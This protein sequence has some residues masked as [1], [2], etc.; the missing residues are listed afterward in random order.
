MAE[1]TSVIE[2]PAPAVPVMDEDDFIAMQMAMDS[3]EGDAPVVPEETGAKEKPAAPAKKK[4]EEKAPTVEP[5][6]GE[7]EPQEGDDAAAGGA[8]ADAGDGNDDTEEEEVLE[9][10]DDVIPG[11]KGE[12]MAAL[13]REAQ[14]NLAKWHEEV[15]AKAAALDT[16]QAELDRVKN[17]P[18]VRLRLAAGDKGIAAYQPTQEDID[19]IVNADSVQASAAALKRIMD[20][21]STRNTSYHLQAKAQEEEIKDVSR[22]TN[23]NLLKAIN[24]NPDYAIKETRLDALKPGHPEFTVYEKGL[25]KMIDSLVA[26]GFTKVQISKMK[27]ESIYA[28]VAAEN[29]WPVALN[30]SERDRKIGASFL[31]KSLHAFLKKP[32]RPADSPGQSMTPTGRDKSGSSRK[33]TH[34]DGIDLVKLASDENYHAEVLDSRAMEEGWVEKVSDYRRRGESVLRAQK[35]RGRGVKE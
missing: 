32:G 30:T 1:E 21:E 5:E 35:A 11:L 9:F 7:P 10:A 22:K 19:A 3:E 6:E 25:S 31:R 23:E 14:L 27:P 26:N 4:P 34:V 17:D 28:A 16:A 20:R 8:G 15:S 18:F 2:K 24:L 13:P 29:G 33:E 12:H